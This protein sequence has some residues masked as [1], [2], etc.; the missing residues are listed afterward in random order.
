VVLGWAG[1]EVRRCGNAGERVGSFGAAIESYPL[2]L[3]VQDCGKSAVTVGHSAEGF[4]G[5]RVE[6]LQMLQG[7][8]KHIFLS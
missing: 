8:R 7:F 6:V 2:L 1:R 5:E 4:D 3:E